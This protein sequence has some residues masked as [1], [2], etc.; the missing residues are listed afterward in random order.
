MTA[1]IQ[2]LIVV[3]MFARLLVL[4][5]VKA[6]LGLMLWVWA[7]MNQIHPTAVA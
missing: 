3:G 6:A 4:L 7:L 5:E 2:N 1:T